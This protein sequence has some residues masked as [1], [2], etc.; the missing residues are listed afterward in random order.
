VVGG[1][2]KD[3]AQAQ[4]VDGEGWQW[5]LGA[6]ARWKVL[7]FDYAYIMPPFL[8][9]YERFT[10]AVAFNSTSRI[11]V[12]KAEVDEVFASQSGCATRRTRWARSGYVALGELVVTLPVF[13][14]GLMDAPTERRSWS[15]C[16]RSRRCR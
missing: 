11:R 12:E 10:A 3:L 2:Q 1:A 5:S 9:P 14:P 7:Q 16:W 8:P 15:G 13:V 6:S 4:G